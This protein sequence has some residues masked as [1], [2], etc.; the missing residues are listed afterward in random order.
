MIF[1]LDDAA[2][3]KAV[4]ATERIRGRAPDYCNFEDVLRKAIRVYIREAP[5]LDG[6]PVITAEQLNR[7]RE[8]R[9]RKI[10]AEKQP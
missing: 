2:F 1:D 7:E 10:E 5:F 9:R 3:E 8:K 6:K 4:A